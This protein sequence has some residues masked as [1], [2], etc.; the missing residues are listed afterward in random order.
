MKTPELP[1]E[2]PVR[3]TWLFSDP[4]RLALVVS[5]VLAP[6]FVGEAA[7]IALS[8]HYLDSV[9]SSLGASALGFLFLVVVPLIVPVTYARLGLDTVHVAR[10]RNRI[11]PLSVALAG[12]VVFWLAVEGIFDDYHLSLA[13][14]VFVWTTPILLAITLRW[15]MSVH[16]LGNSGAV[17]LLSFAWPWA[18]L[19]MLL[20]PPVAWARL[21]LKAHSL[22]QIVAGLLLGTALTIAYL[23]LVTEFFPP[24]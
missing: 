9:G 1:V 21:R 24:S 16:M 17:V 23:M 20:H 7:W 5:N 15:K 4:E 10:R 19:L 13:A 12:Y 2:V 18:A 22:A 3:E 8:F 11:L 14:S 6:V